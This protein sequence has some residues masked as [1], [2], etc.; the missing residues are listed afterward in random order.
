M[1]HHIPHGLV[2]MIVMYLI[3]KEDTTATL[4]GS[5]LGLLGVTLGFAL[6]LLAWQIAL[7]TACCGSSSSS[8]SPRWGSTSARILVLGALGS[9]FGVPAA[10]AMVLPD[11]LPVPDTE[12]M[13]EFVLWLWWCIAL[14]LARQPRRAAPAV[15]GRPA[16]APPSR[17]RRAAPSGGGGRTV[18]RWPCRSRAASGPVVTDFAH[19]SPA[20]PRC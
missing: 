12:A 18:A 3:T 10:M 7:Q 6:A 17:A 11:I 4:L 15:A 14:G 19:A 13:T 20:R 1:I 9:A 16:G 8:C 2:V 5:V